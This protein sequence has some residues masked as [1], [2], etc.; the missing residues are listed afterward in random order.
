VVSSGKILWWM[1]R[2][3]LVLWMDGVV[4][5]GTL[6]VGSHLREHGEV[7]G[8]QPRKNLRHDKVGHVLQQR[9]QRR[10]GRGENR[11][12]H[13]LPREKNSSTGFL[14]VKA[15]GRRRR[16][17][18]HRITAR[19]SSEEETSCAICAGTVVASVVASL[20]VRGG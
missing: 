20:R 19:A 2:R 9:D 11:P 13:P 14:G 10:A 7:G 1:M 6:C 16:R 12:P 18:P 17:Q 5:T 15:E 8:V 3:A 4:R